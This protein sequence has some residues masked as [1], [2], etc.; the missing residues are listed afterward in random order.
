[1][2]NLATLQ[3][4]GTIGVLRI[5]NPP[6]NALSRGVVQGIRQAV[7]QFEADRTLTALVVH[8]DGRTFVAG[9]DI[10][11]FSKPDFEAKTFNATL[12]RIENLDR[13][14]VAALHGTVLGGGLELA[15]AC[16]YRIA[17]ETTRLGLPEVLLGILPGSLGTQRLPRLV[18]VRLALEM[19]LS[20]K[21]IAAAKA[22]DCGLVDAV[23]APAANDALLEAALDHAKTLVREGKGPRRTRERQASMEGLEPDF[24]DKALEE[25]RTKKAAYPAPQRIVRCVQAAATLPFPEGEAMEAA[26]FEEC[27]VSAESVAMRHLFFAERAA[28]KIPGVPSDFTPRAVRK[29]GVLGAGTMGGGIAMNFANAGIPVTIVETSAEALERGLGIVRKNYEAS[30]AKGKLR[31][32]EPARRMNLLAGSLKVEDLADCDMV[33]EAVFENMDIKKQVSKRLGEVCKPGAIIAS[34]T[35]TLDVNV[36]ADASGRPGDFLGM[37]FF[38]P[39]N[40]M[41]LLEIVRGDRTDPEVL[42]TVVKLARTIGKVPV[43]SGVCY[44]FIGNRMLEPYLRESEFLMMEGATPAQID[45]AIQSLGLPMGPCRMLDLAGLDVAAKVVIERGK[46]GGLPDDPSY[47]AVVQKMMELGRFGQKTGAGYY[48]YDGRTPVPD[49]EVELICAALAQEH[50]I[51]RRDNISDQEIIERCVYPLINEGAKILEEGIAYRPGDID[52]VWV[53]GYGFPD[54]RGGPMHMADAVGLQKIAERLDHYAAERKDRHG[55]WSRAGLLTDMIAN[56]RRFAD[57][58][59]K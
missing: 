19:I 46:A 21:P 7:E 42:G 31:P 10:A 13:P 47:R 5:S 9:G 6:V 43:V 12:A 20:G 3:V 23:I 55:Y 39:A 36:L 48:R 18:G 1:M 30:A 58:P 32:D 49:P 52:L 57:W 16:H 50:G 15:M 33:I 29:V 35:S 22:R 41:R 11:E 56:K 40:V 34:N 59:F 38:S 8:A 51:V 45:R 37:H 4:H 14:V 54:F 53:N 2:S 26:L 25:A 24:F 28:G 17:V 27:R 44:G